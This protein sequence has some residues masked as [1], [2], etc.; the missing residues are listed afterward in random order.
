MKRSL[1]LPYFVL[2]VFFIVMLSAQILLAGLSL[3][4]RSSVWETHVGLGHLIPVL[5][6]VLLILALVG[7]LPPRLR[8]WSAVLLAGVLVQTELFV[9][10][11]ELSGA[12][13]AFHPLLAAGLFWGGIVVAQRAWSV[14]REPVPA[15]ARQRDEVA[16]TVTSSSRGSLDCDPAA[17]PSC[18][19]TA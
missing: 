8:T 14:Y 15:G 3:T 13:A 1:I 19:A 10:I 9:L 7:R 2:T 17:D 12:A 11:R 6:F 4:W 16:G 5:P 18:R